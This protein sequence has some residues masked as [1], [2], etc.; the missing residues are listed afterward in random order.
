MTCR[1][2][3]TSE[4]LIFKL[5]NLA[6]KTEECAEVV[7]NYSHCWAGKVTTKTKRNPEDPAPSPR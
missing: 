2:K 1:L 4:M 3:D 7:S 6:I 5:P